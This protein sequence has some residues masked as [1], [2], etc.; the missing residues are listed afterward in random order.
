MYVKVLSSSKCTTFK[1]LWTFDE[2]LVDASVQSHQL[3]G[4]YVDDDRFSQWEVIMSYFLQK[5]HENRDFLQYIWEAV[6]EPFEHTH[7]QNIDFCCRT[8]L[9]KQVCFFFLPTQYE[10]KGFLPM[11]QEAVDELFQHTLAQSVMMGRL[12]TFN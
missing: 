8:L 3:R 11:L 12:E 5:E 10:N 6:D 2:R 1:F 7:S 4:A 9:I